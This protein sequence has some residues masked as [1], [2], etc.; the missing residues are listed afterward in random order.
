MSTP[1]IK[2]EMFAIAGIHIHLVLLSP[3][4][5]ADAFSISQLDKSA[6]DDEL[7]FL[8][9][10][11]P[12]D[13]IRP[14]R[15]SMIGEIDSDWYIVEDPTMGPVGSDGYSNAEFELIRFKR[16]QETHRLSPVD[17]MLLTTLLSG[18]CNRAAKEAISN[19]H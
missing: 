19:A 7:F 4:F 1:P 14:I 17:K 16:W 18:F 12:D 2:E 13:V 10:F 11:V 9:D 6:C 3:L 8:I 5:E 15:M